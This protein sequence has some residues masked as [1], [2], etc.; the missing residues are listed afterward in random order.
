M[1]RVQLLALR[2]DRLEA[3]QARLACFQQAHMRRLAADAHGA[4]V[5]DLDRRRRLAQQHRRFR[6]AHSSLADSLRL[7]R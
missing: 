4:H 7:G 3:D 5:D 2:L 1:Q 6:K